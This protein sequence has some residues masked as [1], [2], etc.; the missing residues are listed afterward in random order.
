M[1]VNF[2]A[3]GFLS[4]SLLRVAAS[5]LL[6]SGAGISPMWAAPGLK[7][8]S[9]VTVIQQNSVTISGRIV[10]EKGESL[11]G[12]NIVV[13][14]TTNGTI[15]DADGK[16][17]IKTNPKAVLTFSYIGYITQD[18][19][20]GNQKNISI[21]LKEDTKTFD[22]IIV[23]AYGTSKKSSFTG[24]VSVVSADKLAKI[25][26][27]NITQGLQGLSSGV[28]VIN[29]SGRP[30]EDAQIVIRGLGSMTASAT[31][32]Y[33]ID[34]VPS[35]VPLNSYSASDIESISVM[36]DA[37]STSL[38][39]SRAGNGVIMITTKKGKEGKTKVNARANWGTSEFAVKFPEKVSAAKQYELAFEGLYND[40]TDF[41]GKSDADARQYAYDK[42][43]SVFWNKTPIT[44]NDGTTRNYRSG[45][46]MDNPVG[47]D[48]KIK[49]D[50]K[51]LWEFDAFDEAFSHRMKQDYGADISGALGDKNN[52]FASFSMLDD[53]GVH[54]SDHF[55]RFTGRG[56]LNTKVNKWLEMSN[57]IMYSNS[58]T[59][60]G[61][62]GTRVFRVLPSEYSAYLW[63]YQKNQYAISPFTGKP[64]LDEG[65]FNGRAWWPGWS[66]FGS[67]TEAVDNKN[68]NLQTISAFTLNLMKGLT[69]RTTYSYQLSSAFN[70]NWRSPEREDVVIA[71][72]GR[73]DRSSTR[74]TSK[75]INNVL[76]YD[77]T[78]GDHHMNLMAGQ[79]AYKYKTVGFGISRAGLDLPYFTEIS[80]A[81]K[82]PTGWSGTDNY[83]LASYFSK[84]DYDYKNR[85]YIS[86][87]FRTDGSSRFH[88]DNRWGKFWSL[89]S[90]WRIT[91]EEFM[92]PTASWLNNLKL[93]FSYGE[94]GNDNVGFY[95]YQ[96]L[97][98]PEGS[99]YAGNIGVT[100]SQIANK[101]VKWET[102]VQMN[103]GIEFSLFN[104]LTG[105]FELFSR[106][107]KDL[108]LNTPLPSSVGMESI[109][110]NIGDIQNTGWEVELNYQA[111]HTK[112]F[113][114]NIGFNATGYKN[115]ITSLPSKEEQFNSGIAIF[116]WKEGGSRYDIYAPSWAGVNPDN[117]RNQW[118]KYSFDENGN[119][120]G[121]TKTE[122]YSEVNTNDQRIKQGSML[123]DA[124]G[125]VT[126]NFKYKNL[127]LSFMFYYSIGGK[128][129]D[130]NYGESNVLRENF[131]AYDILD[132]RWK[133]PG[134]VT[135]VAKIYTYQCFNA[136]SYARYSDKYLYDN[137]FVRFRNLTL[138][139]SLPKS[140]LSKAGIEG[141]RVYV[142]GD[143]LLTFGKQ[144]KH[145]SDPENGALTGVID[146]SSPIPTLRSY[147]VGI[148]LSF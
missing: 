40:A 42:V 26:P 8:N 44:L 47:L 125:S 67:L 86:G 29:N 121:K 115:K 30:G 108:L 11:P 109:L 46:N 35:D 48:G 107:S 84:A 145:G 75:T 104:K 14:G 83:T 7:E 2:S 5:V 74:S 52:Y 81:S 21:R 82:D 12:V 132:R 142:K 59:N 53:K 63:D 126:N 51:R 100:Q 39:G 124:Y 6:I 1:K 147:N 31:P 54:L 116:K 89:G 133:K 3:N 117:G 49:A 98:T 9:A 92:K 32:L 24:S 94:V 27:T 28:Q 20:I 45:W 34:G 144:A 15:S 148:N 57:T 73:V 111:V 118:W 41:L 103:G 58:T 68:D 110:K 143:N 136:N 95:A 135:D 131:S 85:Y 140:L 56:V 99:S 113:D 106:K 18:I 90:S 137:T 17:T 129:Y 37:A 65:R 101:D 33:V 4:E 138:G 128:V 91:Q 22:E 43:T 146:G 122:S 120:T 55:K 25:A 130:Y 70:Y 71:S 16:F 61:G 13:R 96:G 77:K 38:Y 112:D 141:V 10:G 76:T 134:D 139:Y 69:L 50:A 102:N 105:S 64:Q 97:Y 60:N 79:E 23:T 93:K 78:F 119:I 123:P 72:E 19:A 80:T 88:P 114:W 62:F 66:V 87:S 127:D 36:K